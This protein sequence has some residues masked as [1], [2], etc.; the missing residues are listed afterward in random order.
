MDACQER[1]HPCAK[2]PGIGGIHCHRVGRS[3]IPH[4]DRVKK[5]FPYRSAAMSRWRPTRQPGQDCQWDCP[6]PV[7]EF[8]SHSRVEISTRRPS[9]TMAAPKARSIQ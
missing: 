9:A 1:L 7:T 5:G 8:R 2:V 6:A 4:P 3:F